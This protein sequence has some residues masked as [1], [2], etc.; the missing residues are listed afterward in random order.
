M[1][2][3]NSNYAGQVAGNVSKRGYISVGIDARSFLAHRVIW[4]LVTGEDPGNLLDHKDT[5]KSNN[6]WL[7]LRKATKQ[8]NGCNRGV[9]ANSKT[10]IKGVS[11]DQARNKFFASISLN[12]KTKALGRFDSADEARAAYAQ[13]AKSLHGEFAKAF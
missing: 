3:F 2:T 1:N 11:W 7:N 9:P 10:G 8:Q 4:V 6:R 5:D 12:G 13:A